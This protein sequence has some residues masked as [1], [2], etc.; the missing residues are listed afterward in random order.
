MYLETP[1][2]ARAQRTR[3]PTVRDV[4]D[5][6]AYSLRYSTVRPIAADR[7]TPAERTAIVRQPTS[8]RHIWHWTHAYSWVSVARPIQSGPDGEKSG[9]GYLEVTSEE[10]HQV[11]GQLTATGSNIAAE[12]TQAMA[13]VTGLVNEGWQGAGD[14]VQRAVHPV[15]DELRQA[16]RVAQR[17]Q[18]AAQRRRLRVRGDRG[19]CR[20]LD[21]RQLSPLS[22]KQ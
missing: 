17:H 2:P 6:I 10:L 9:M 16:P 14:A 12:N 7:S 1:E 11:A 22:G 20:P 13:K 18:P 4:G 21:D 5:Q 15:E 3:C 8:G 19:R